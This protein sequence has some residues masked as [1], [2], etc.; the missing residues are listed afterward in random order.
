MLL[1]LALG[2]I[3][4]A[5]WVGGHRERRGAALRGT[6][7]GLG[8]LGLFRIG[9]IYFDLRGRGGW[10][11]AG[12]VGLEGVMGG[13]NGRIGTVATVLLIVLFGFL[14]SCASYTSFPEHVEPGTNESLEPGYARI[15]RWRQV[16]AYNV[17]IEL[18]CATMSDDRKDSGEWFLMDLQ[19]EPESVFDAV[20]SNGRPVELEN[21]KDRYRRE[22]P[23]VFC[24]LT[25][26]RPIRTEALP[27]GRRIEIYRAQVGLVKKVEVRE[28]TLRKEAS[29]MRGLNLR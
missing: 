26:D 13:V 3:P 8:A 10:A 14:P 6:G 15:E 29:V 21:W 16:D 20:D 28:L 11:V 9:E 23:D 4:R 24:I 7:R 5:D 27:N 12:G 2:S 17:Q 18:A 1:V 22:N 19:S 25:R